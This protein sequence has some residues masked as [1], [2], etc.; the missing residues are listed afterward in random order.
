MHGCGL[1]VAGVSEPGVL[2]LQSCMV[3]GDHE[4]DRGRLWRTPGEG[5]N[6]Q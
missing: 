4:L 2:K 1:L 6:I 3:E 5:D